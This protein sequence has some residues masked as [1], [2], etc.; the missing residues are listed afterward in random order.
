MRNARWK[1]IMIVLVLVMVSNGLSQSQTAAQAIMEAKDL[2]QQGSNS[3]SGD[4]F[5]QANNI[6]SQFETQ[7]DYQGLAAYYLGYIDYQ[8]AVVVYRMDK[9]KAPA[10]LDSAVVHLEKALEI[11]DN[12]AE[13]RALLSSCY[14]MQIA[15]SPFSGIWRGPKSGS[16][17]S[18]A[19]EL[20]GENP[21]VA[22]LGAIGTYNTPALFGGG[23]EKGFEAMKRAAELFDRWKTTDSLQPDWGKEQVYAW[24]GLA[25]LDRKETILARKAFEKALEINPDYGWVK[26]VLMPKVT[27]EA[28]SHE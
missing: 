22:L 2:I 28:E 15:F 17:M 24:I 18:K 10:S 6:L 27:S 20:A 9:E 4:K 7:G 21:R 3:A 25:Y 13:S 11:N 12:D 5:E 26:Y 1:Y 8:M 23:K 14:G 19:K 16:Q